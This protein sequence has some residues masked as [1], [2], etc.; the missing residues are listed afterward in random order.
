M[1]CP[2]LKLYVVLG[3]LD[4]YGNVLLGVVGRIK[5]SYFIGGE[6]IYSDL[7]LMFLIKTNLISLPL[8]FY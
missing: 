6:I 7:S 5:G 3:C 8:K 1:L 2:K 4:L